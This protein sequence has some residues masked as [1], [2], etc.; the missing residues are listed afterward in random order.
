MFIWGPN[1][2]DTSRNPVSL[3][4]AQS[5]VATG[6]DF[7]EVREHIDMQLDSVKNAARDEKELSEALQF[8]DEIAAA[9]TVL[10]GPLR[11]R[12][13]EKLQTN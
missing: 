12:N 11:A 6:L 4:R 5:Y 9:T 8:G 7:K 10:E 1:K 3:A 2:Y 13:L